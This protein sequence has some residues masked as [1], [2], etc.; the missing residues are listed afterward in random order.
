LETFKAYEHKPAD[1]IKGRVNP[2][3]MSQLTDCLT[4][5]RSVNKT[6][7]VTLAST[8][9]SL[10][11]IM[12]ASTLELSLCP[13][14]GEAKA[15]RIHDAFHDPFIAEKSRRLAGPDAGGQV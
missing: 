10:K 5:I 13:G 9:G 2:D 8:F 7:V 6:D 1:I 4:S 3:Y 11:R 15:K 14:I 12:E